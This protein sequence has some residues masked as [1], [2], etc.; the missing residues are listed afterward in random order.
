MSLLASGWKATDAD[1]AVFVKPAPD[2]SMN[3]LLNY[4]DDVLG[5]IAAD[6]EEECWRS[7]I[8]RYES[9]PPREASL[10]LGCRIR[11]SREGVVIVDQSE[12]AEHLVARYET[13]YG[14]PAKM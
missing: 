7:I 3:V 9:D 1:Q 2:G 8:G 10:F 14:S 12:Y 11:T 5:S 6:G 4:V 13:E